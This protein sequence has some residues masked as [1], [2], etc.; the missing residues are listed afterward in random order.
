MK[1]K[2]MSNLSNVPIAIVCAFLVAAAG[3]FEGVNSAIAIST[4]LIIALKDF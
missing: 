2:N 1:N 3:H 4:Y